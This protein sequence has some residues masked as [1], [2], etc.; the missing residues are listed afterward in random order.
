MSLR[1]LALSLCLLSISTVTVGANAK[2]TSAPTAIRRTLLEHYELSQRPGWENRLYLIE[3]GPG[4]IA[5]LHHHPIEGAG[6]VISG[7]FDSQFAGGQVTTVCEGQS[8]KDK[9][10][11]AHVLFRNSSALRDLKFVISY[12]VQ[13]E[14]PV[15]ETP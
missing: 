5:P 3:Y 4:A 9:A 2:E 12:V 1:I 10:A 15:V 14:S 13:K 6:Y 7:C 11:V 8:F